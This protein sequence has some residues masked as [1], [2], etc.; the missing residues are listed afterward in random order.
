MN[1]KNR[2]ILNILKNKLHYL[3]ALWD[4]KGSEEYW[5]ER[6]N[7]G[8]NSGSGSYGKFAEFKAEVLNN[9]VQ[10]REIKSVIEF[11]CGD[12]NQLKYS[13][14]RNYLGFDVSFDAISRCQK[15]FSHDKKMVFKLMKE[16]SGEKSDLSISLDVIYHLVEKKSFEEYM[17]TLFGAAER[18][19][20]IYSSDSDKNYGVAQP[21]IKRRKITKWIDQN[22][23]GW[24]LID[25]IPN[26][27]EW[28]GD[29]KNSSVS[30]FIIYK[31]I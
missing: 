6:Y 16:Y 8:R 7:N 25:R 21:H 19:V 9:F 11:G 31:H 23:K 13:N 12:G 14:Y 4:F 15:L 27:Y 28:N 20:I 3:K 18:Y 30:I 10:N 5:I 17:Y 22:I 1:R 29:W 26:R 24:K 2:N